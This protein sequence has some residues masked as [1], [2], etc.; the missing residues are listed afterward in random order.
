MYHYPLSTVDCLSP[1][2]LACVLLCSRIV[3]I[4]LGACHSAFQLV[5]CLTGS[6]RKLRCGARCPGWSIHF[7]FIA[8]FGT[9]LSS[10]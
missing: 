2:S 5:L 3:P 4:V 10:V 6:F 8:I 9:F 7:S 1:L